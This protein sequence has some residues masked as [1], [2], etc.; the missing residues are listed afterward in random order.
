LPIDVDTVCTDAD[1]EGYA[2]GAQALQTLCPEEWLTTDE[3]KKTAKPARQQALNI[4]MTKLLRRSPP[5]TEDDIEEPT[6]LKVVVAYGSMWLLYMGAATSEGSPNFKR[7][8]AYRKL[9]DAELDALLPTVDEDGDGEPD[10]PSSPL[11]V[12]LE[13]G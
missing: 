12:T 3:T 2:L 11:G 4:V 13:R 10:G 5:V 6:E 9:F 1:L 7:A 8:E